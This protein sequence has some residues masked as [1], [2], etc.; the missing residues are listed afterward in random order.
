ME[1]EKWYVGIDIGTTA[2]KAVCFTL[3]GKVI[4]EYSKEYPMYHPKA[5]QSTQKPNEILEAVFEC[6]QEI[7]ISGKPEF[8]SFS[9][10]MQSILIIDELGNPLT[11][12]ILWADNRAHEL[13]EDLKASE[14]GRSFYNTTGI[15]I[16]TFS[17]MTKIAWLKEHEEKLFSKAFKF[18]SLKEYVWHQLT[19]EYE[20]DSSMASGAGL[21]NIYTLEW[22]S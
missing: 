19:G 11:D 3:A 2:T 12:A 21:M 15:P 6:I 1:N 4:Q 20:I 5:N 22:D 17:P 14:Q 18:I 13:A 10:A 8:I 7:T 9:S 16:H